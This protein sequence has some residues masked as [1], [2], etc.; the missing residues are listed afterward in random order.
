MR[1]GKVPY[2]TF[3]DWLLLVKWQG[4][5]H[6]GNL[7][8]ITYQ[9]QSSVTIAP[10]EGHSV[11]RPPAGYEICPDCHENRLVEEYKKNGIMTVTSWNADDREAA[12]FGGVVPV[13]QDWQ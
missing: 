11:Y 3:S 5:V 10:F 4:Q 12:H 6:Q 13:P 7:Q 1:K 8:T 2:A 9:G